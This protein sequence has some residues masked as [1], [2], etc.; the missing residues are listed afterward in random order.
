MAYMQQVK[1]EKLRDREDYQSKKD[2]IWNEYGQ[3]KGG[4]NRSQFHKQKGHPSLSASA[5]APR[6]KSEHHKQNLQNFRAR[7]AQSQQTVAQGGN[8]DLAFSKCNRTH[9]SE[10]SNDKQVFLSVGKRVTS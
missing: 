7:P 10:C 2:K 9:R 5:R 4:T 6:N 1:E 8:W 3:Q